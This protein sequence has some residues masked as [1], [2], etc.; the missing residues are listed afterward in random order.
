MT[1]YK[2]TDTIKTWPTL[3]KKN[4]KGSLQQWRIWTEENV[5]HTEFGRVGGKLQTT[6]DVIHN[7]KNTGKVN[8]TNAVSQCQ[9]EA[10]SKYE[11]QLKKRY[12]ISLEAAQNGEVDKEMVQGGIPPMLSINKSH[13]KDPILD[14]Y[15][16]YP[17]FVQPKLD[18]VCCI[19]VIENGEATLWSRTQ[20]PITSMPHI[21]NELE[22]RFPAP[23][24]I[25]LH[26]ELYTHALKDEFENLISI[27]R[28]E[29]PDEAGLYKCMEY[30]VYDMPEH[31]K[32]KF[33][34]NTPYKNRYHGYKQILFDTRLNVSEDDKDYKV[35]PVNSAL[36]ENKDA[37]IGN[38]E[39]NLEFG[40]EGAMAK[41]LDA[42][43]ESGKRS[44]N[45]LK[46]K[47]SE[48]NEFK[49]IGALEGRG[50]D[51]GTVGSFLCVTNDGKEF[52][53][54]LKTTWKHRKELFDNPA[55]W[56]NQW[57]TVKYQNLTKEGIPR[58]PVGKGL[59]K[60][61]SED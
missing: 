14:K 4:N 6:A 60:G 27:V 12:V 53:V 13:P 38:Y 45:L 23:G 8:E 49:V 7:G 21:V 19:A 58:F 9:A 37:V 52:A 36:C 3:Y 44:Y 35:Q 32:V 54:R 1:P 15:L 18:G 10:Q 59:R 56:E 43:Y 42:P 40:F 16:K 55:M 39:I 34:K 61:P 11:R 29:E 5:I 17:C 22:K 26:G 25:V 46:M 47:P 41:N 24:R 57:L 2:D 50:K 28:Q 30:W 20:K 51:A 31:S 33:D 48:D